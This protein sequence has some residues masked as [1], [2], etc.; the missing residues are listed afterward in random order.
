MDE[1]VE[2]PDY[3]GQG[4]KIPKKN[5]EYWL[6]EDKEFYIKLTEQIYRKQLIGRHGFVPEVYVKITD[7]SDQS[8][9]KYFGKK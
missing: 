2:D 3:K 5:L 1:L 8:K 4:A 6:T 9:S 7:G